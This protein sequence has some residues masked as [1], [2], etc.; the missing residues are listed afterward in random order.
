MTKVAFGFFIVGVLA[1]VLGA[2]NIAGLSVD[3]GVLL[4][5]MFL[6][7][8]LRSILVEMFSSEKKEIFK[9]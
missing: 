7:L 8:A 4:M 2:N 6:A 9:N 3:Y 1:Y 5:I